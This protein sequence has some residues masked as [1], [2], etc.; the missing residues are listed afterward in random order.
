MNRQRRWGGDENDMKHRKASVSWQNDTAELSSKE[1]V[2]TSRLRTGYTKATHRHIIEKI[3][4][5]DCS[6]CDLRL[7]ADHILWQC[8]ETR[9]ETDDYWTQSTAW[10][11]DRKGSKNLVQYIR[12]IGLI[13]GI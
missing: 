11:E 2:V 5:P 9:N 8:S 1:Q 6:F 12:K 13:H 10:K 4:L 3:N 7:T